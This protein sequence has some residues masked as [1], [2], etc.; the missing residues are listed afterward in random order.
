MPTFSESIKQ[1]ICHKEYDDNC[2]KAIFSSFLANKLKLNL[3]ADG[4]K[5][6]IESNFSFIIHFITGII[7]KFYPK[8]N[9]ELSYS[10]INKLNKKRTYRL[11]IDENK[12]SPYIE[13]LDIYKYS[14]NK[15]NSDYLKRS[16]LVGAFLSGGSISDTSKSVY[17]LEIK[18]TNI[19]YIRFIQSLLIGYNIS[20]TILKRKYSLVLYIKRANEVSDFLKIIG[21]N[22][23]MNKLE[24][25]IISRD[26]SNQIH[27][28]NN[29]DVSNINKSINAG[30]QQIEMINKL[31]ASELYLSQ[32]LR[33]K[34]F[35]ELR[36]AN[37]TVSL[38][39]IVNL[40]KKKHNFV[41]SRTGMN[42]YVIK[43]KKLY[44]RIKKY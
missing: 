9:F 18:S 36:L 35:C 40:F 16:Y 10:D 7:K 1:E 32:S 34:Q 23:N 15:F 17:H 13:Q 42:H 30:N 14:L 37:P 28:L 22:D 27:R 41:I 31:Q 43:L 24:D 38:S 11:S 25:T 39:E 33:F 20:P 12:L 21:A 3:S 19:N 2:L 29:L 26:L 5:W 44:E 6:Y 4:C 8:L